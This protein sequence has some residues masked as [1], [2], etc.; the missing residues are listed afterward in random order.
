MGY[1]ALNGKTDVA[2][3]ARKHSK[4][5]ADNDYFSHDNKQGESPFDRM[6]NDG[7]SFLWQLVKTLPMANQAVSLHMKA[8]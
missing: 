1:T 2:G 5:M 7:N 6:K 3:T 4:D 8:L